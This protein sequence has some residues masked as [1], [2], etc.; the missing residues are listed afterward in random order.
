MWGEQ[1]DE[2]K[3][4]SAGARDKGEEGGSCQRNEVPVEG[5]LM[6]LSPPVLS[7]QRT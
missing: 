4:A 2:W 6:Q 7:S 5:H 1:G 3:E